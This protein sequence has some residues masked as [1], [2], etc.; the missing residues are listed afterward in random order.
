MTDQRWRSISLTIDL[1][2]L[3]GCATPK[4]DAFYYIYGNEPLF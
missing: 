2:L 3:I 4:G 1:T